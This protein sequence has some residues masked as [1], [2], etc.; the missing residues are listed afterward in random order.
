M[1]SAGRQ[2]VKPSARN[3]ASVRKIANRA[4]DA[5]IDATRLTRDNG[6]TLVLT[7][8]RCPRLASTLTTK[9]EHLSPAGIGRAVISLEGNVH[10]PL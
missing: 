9:T 8:L 3:I 1:D 4:P 2:G 10:A 7:V 5:T 6:V